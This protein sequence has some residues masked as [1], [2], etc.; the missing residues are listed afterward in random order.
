MVGRQRKP[1][2]TIKHNRINTPPEGE[3]L[4]LKQIKSKRLGRVGAVMVDEG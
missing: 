1:N 2:T 4:H 3:S